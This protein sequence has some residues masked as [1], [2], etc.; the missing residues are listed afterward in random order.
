L[1]V[2][3]PTPGEGRRRVRW[4]HVAAGAIVVLAVGCVAAF[5]V[6]RPRLNDWARDQAVTFLADTFDSEVELGAL[7][8][9][10]GTMFRVTGSDL[11]LRHKGRRDVPPL[12]VVAA[13]EVWTPLPRLFGSPRVVERVE[14]D[15]LEFNIPPRYSDE[16]ARFPNQTPPSEK[17]EE[18]PA[19]T[20]APKP[21]VVAGPAR[22]PG[23]ARL[24]ISQLVARDARLAIIP[25]EGWKPPK[26]WA[27]RTLS[28]SD[29]APD[30]P[31]PFTA[32][33]DNP[34][35]KGVVVASGRFGPWAS[36]EPGTTPLDGTYT[37]EQADLGVFKGIGG[38]VDAA[39]TFEGV[40]ERIVAKGTSTTPDFHLDLAH[41][42]IPL[43]TEYTSVI[44][45]TNGNT[46]LDPVHATLGSTKI[47][48]SGGI[49]KVTRDAEGRTIDLDVAIEEGRLEDV[50]RLVVE[51][52]E[53]LMT[54]G[55]VTTAKLLIPP[56]DVPVS[57]KI[58]LDGD[59]RLDGAQFTS[60]T[61]QGKVDELSRRAQGRPD[62]RNIEDVLS[63]F[64]GRFR[65]RDGAI[66]FPVLR[67][68]TQGA[69][70]QMAGAYYVDGRLDFTGNIRMTA[71]VSRMVTGKKRHFLRMFDPLF[72]RD[73][74]TEF[75]I[76][77]RGSVQ[78]PEF[79]VNV[80]KTLRQALLPGD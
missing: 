45:G 56:G 8:V 43:T 21:E 74:A 64:S 6:L 40:L 70:V 39:G 25:K 34:L 67:F 58:Q 54:G 71:G 68:T 37:L 23:P 49:V 50:L 7:D 4:W 61:V 20:S 31:M 1:T 60:D 62:A 69:R 42:P 10:F 52:E 65:M 44:D 53:P 57:R 47:R 16:E 14:I 59:F 78:E 11:V 76:H 15:G 73:G 41:Q 33:I 38:I 9:Q 66:R 27:I 79:G 17:P 13:F 3:N 12:I 51:G 22:E 19:P 48:A 63:D 32:E 2:F 77:V 28:M 75:P 18:A 80:K 55:L 24:V 35:P 36:G 29:L 46:W 5:F 26:V 30:R 72:R